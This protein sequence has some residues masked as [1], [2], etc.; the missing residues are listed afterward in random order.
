MRNSQSNRRF[1]CQ[2]QFATKAL[3][4]EFLQISF[5]YVGEK[6]DGMHMLMTLCW[7]VQWISC[8]DS[9]FYGSYCIFLIQKSSGTIVIDEV[10]EFFISNSGRTLGFLKGKFPQLNFIATTHSADLIA[11]AEETNLILLYGENFEILDA[12]RDFSSISQVYDIFSVF[13]EEKKNDKKARWY[14]WRLFNNKMSGIWN[15]KFKI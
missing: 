15:Q 5:W 2:L 14:T 3:M 7:S 11:N 1:L 13:F 6:W 4:D 9:H 10:D 12:V 8:I